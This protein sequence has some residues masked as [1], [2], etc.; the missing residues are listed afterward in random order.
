MMDSKAQ[1]FDSRKRTLLIAVLKEK[2][3]ISVLVLEVQ[4][5]IRFLIL[6]NSRIVW[7]WKT[8]E[9]LMAKLIIH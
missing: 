8:L 2:V 6:V 4:M 9:V 7:I 5:E 3:K 1:P